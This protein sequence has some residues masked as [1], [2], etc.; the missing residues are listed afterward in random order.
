MGDENTL[1]TTADVR[2]LLRRAGQGPT[3]R[4]VQRLEGTTR[5]QAAD[6]LLA[7]RP[8]PFRPGG[9][10]F[11]KMHEKWMKYLVK[12]SRPLQNKLVLFWHDHFSVNISTVN[13]T[14]RMAG[15]V[16]LLH[17][18]A[19]GNL[20]DF[21]KA[22][23][24]DAAMMDFLD[25]RR[26]D[27]EIPN[28]NYSRELLELFTLG[29]DD[30]LGQP[31]YV[32]ED[33]VQIARAF[34]GWR[35]DDRDMPFLRTNQHDFMAEFPGRGP[36]AI[37]EQTGGFGAGGA[38]FAANGEG[39]AE[40]G[41]V[42]D[43]VFAHEDSQGKNTVARRTTH[44]LLEYLSH[45]APSLAAVDAVVA[46]SGFDT[47]FDIA[48]LV[49]AILVHDVFW[50]TAAP[51]PWGPATPKSVK[52]PVDYVASTM[53]LLRMKL[54]G[55]PTGVQGGA[56]L[57]IT[58]QME[59]MGQTVLDPPSVFGWD[60]ELGWVSSSTLLARYNFARDLVAARFGG[61]RFKPEKLMD[62]TLTDPVAIVDAVLEVLGIPDQVEA[63]EHAAWVDYL[64]DGGLSPTLDLFD[65][66]V[67]STKLHGLFALVMQSPAFQLH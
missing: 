14:K 31:N 21:T 57:S 63:A 17:Q 41:T 61:G 50:E 28:E 9:R 24:V 35:L 12:G 5:G 45:D 56:F 18:H 19:L 10:D 1:L 6:Q 65:D 48:A 42:T 8:K 36:K 64:T 15:Y 37:F 39:E 62:L 2:H 49:R 22:I 30:L 25:T 11:E 20:R 58:D 7:K 54:T 53:R 26:N 4:E 67:R 52:W 40:I 27:K 32:Q 46:A 60:W 23:N 51:A 16:R 66:A 43:I 55:R 34:T 33:V 59:R 38:N 3:P 44:R 29:V 47:S 13:D